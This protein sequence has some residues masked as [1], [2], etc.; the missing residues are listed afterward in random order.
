[1]EGL[2]GATE[3]RN[4]ALVHVKRAIRDFVTG[5]P[6]LCKVGLMV[7]RDTPGS[8]GGQQSHRDAYDAAFAARPEYQATPAPAWR[9]I[10]AARPDLNPPGS[11]DCFRWQGEPDETS[12]TGRT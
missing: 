3:H 7:L 4:E 11:L 10:E 6:H 9:A 1:M 2:G 5:F 12:P 8:R